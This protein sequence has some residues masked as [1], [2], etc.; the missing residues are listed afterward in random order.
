MWSALSPWVARRDSPGLFS[1]LSNMRLFHIQGPLTYLIFFNF[2]FVSYLPSSALTLFVI[3]FPFFSL[4]LLCDHIVQ[5]H[6]LPAELEC[7]FDCVDRSTTSTR[8][9]IPSSRQTFHSPFTNNIAVPPHIFSISISRFLL[10]SIAYLTPHSCNERGRGTPSIGEGCPKVT[11]WP[12]AGC[13]GDLF[14][15]RKKKR[16]K[17]KWGVFYL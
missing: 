17:K 3:Y 8:N 2:F 13:V 14:K 1:V 6:L 15:R 5:A 11:S 9:L 10:T 12:C 16:K 4:H 7:G